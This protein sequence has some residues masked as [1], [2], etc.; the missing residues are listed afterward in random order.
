MDKYDVLDDLT[1]RLNR[2]IDRLSVPMANE[3]EAERA[4]LNAKAEGFKVVKDWVRGYRHY[5]M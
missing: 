5:G 2:A 4:R 3:T 1:E